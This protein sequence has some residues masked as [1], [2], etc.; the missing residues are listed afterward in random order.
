[1]EAQLR[2]TSILIEACG[3]AGETGNGRL[4]NPG[5]QTYAAAA[6]L[7]LYWDHANKT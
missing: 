6:C 4:M 3:N 2:Q 5:D 1:M 7:L